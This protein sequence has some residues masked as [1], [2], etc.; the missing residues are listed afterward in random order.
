MPIR[1]NLLS[2]ALAAE[3]MRRR[4]PVK[5]AA[6]IGGFLVVL[7]L[8]WYSYAWLEGKMALQSKAKVD[9]EIQSSTNGFTQVQI[10]LKKVNDGQRRLDALVQLSTNRFLYGN[11]L[12]ALQ[13]VYV[14]N[15]QLIRMKV[16]QGY[17]VKEGAPAQTN[18][19]GTVPGRPGS[20]T[21]HITLILDAKDASP[22][23]GDGVNRYKEAISR[24]QFFKSN[25]MPTNGIRLVST[26]AAQNGPNGK[27]YIIFVLE[28]RFPDKNR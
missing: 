4:D 12:N 16:E 8:V 2:E 27:P 22:N 3:E 28:C 19:Y 14:P 17:T 25:L 6:F 18:A 7:S 23:P 26:S 15:V 5:R 13:H 10:D 1:I 9:G 21:E 24:E 20:S 11:L